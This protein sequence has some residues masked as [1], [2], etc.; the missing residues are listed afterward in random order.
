MI[1]LFLQTPWDQAVHV[2]A[3]GS[4]PMVLR[5]LVLNTVIVLFWLVRRSRGAPPMR[6]I[7]AIQVQ[8]LLVIANLLILFQTNVEQFISRHI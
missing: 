1:K 6:Q 7:T 2:L 8:S 4:P 3:D 5:I